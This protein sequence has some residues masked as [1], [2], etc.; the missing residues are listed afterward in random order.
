[1]LSKDSLVGTTQDG[2][3]PVARQRKKAKCTLHL[4]TKILCNDIRMRLIKMV[5]VTGAASRQAHADQVTRCK[6]QLGGA[7]WLAEQGDGA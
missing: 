5:A 1:M 4:A 2:E 7:A 6:T 3:E